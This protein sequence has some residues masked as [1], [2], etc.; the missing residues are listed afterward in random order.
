MTTSWHHHDIVGAIIMELH[1]NWKWIV[2]INLQLSCNELQLCAT[3]ATCPSTFTTYKYNELQT[4][5]ATQKLNCKASCKTPIF[6]IML[7]EEVEYFKELRIRWW[8]LMVWCCMY[9]WVVLCGYGWGRELVL[10][11]GKVLHRIGV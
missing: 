6:F 8:G 9:G 7:I 3:H 10:Q 4:Y 5:F 1:N 11:L 2:L